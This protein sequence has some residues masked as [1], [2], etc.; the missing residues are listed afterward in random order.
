MDILKDILLPVILAVIA[1]GGFW[2]F[3]EKCHGTKRAEHELLMGM[4]RNMMMDQATKYLCRGDWITRTEYD[5]LVK[6]MYTPYAKAHGNHGMD[7][8]IS[9]IDD[10]LRIVN[11][12]EPDGSYYISSRDGGI[13]K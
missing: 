10:K 4:A 7:K 1:S 12:P 13:A 3:L 9:D 8:V 11:E 5:N 6:Y 2:A